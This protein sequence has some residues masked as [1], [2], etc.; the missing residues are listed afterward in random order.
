MFNVWEINCSVGHYL[1]DVQATQHISRASF[2][3]IC[4]GSEFHDTDGSTDKLA[5]F[6]GNRW[7]GH[8]SGRQH[9]EVVAGG[10]VGR[11]TERFCWVGDEGRRDHD[12]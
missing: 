1:H 2:L 3:I 6:A 4:Y 10:G 8:T 5:L 11:K 12:K 7:R 9:L